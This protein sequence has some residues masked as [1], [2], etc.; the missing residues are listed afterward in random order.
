MTIDAT[1]ANGR[2]LRGV[3]QGPDTYGTTAVIAAESAMRLASPAKG[4]AGV[5]TPAQAF[6]PVDFLAALA[7]H[8]IQWRIEAA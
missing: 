2:K 8:G 6:Q 4:K 7:P 5:L 1:G 3:V